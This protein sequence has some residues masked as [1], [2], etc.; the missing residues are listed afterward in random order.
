MLIDIGDSGFEMLDSN[1]VA[2]EPWGHTMPVALTENPRTASGH[3]YADRTGVAYEFPP[4]YRRLI[5]PGTPFVYHRGWE[6]RSGPIYF[7]TGIVGDV[8]PSP[9]GGGLLMADILGFEPFVPPVPFK[10]EE[11]RY[12][13][14]RAERESGYYRQGARRI[15]DE[16]FAAI[17]AAAGREVRSNGATPELPIPTPP[18]PAERD[19]VERYAVERVLELLAEMYGSPAEVKEMPHNHPGYDVRVE[20]MDA[21][22]VRYVEVKGTRSGEPLFRLT[23]GERR[24][25]IEHSNVYTFAM[26]WSIDLEAK[27]HRIEMRDG[28]VDA[29]A[30]R[31]QPTGWIGAFPL[32]NR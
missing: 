16:E 23:E 12:F 9:N 26:V 29:A 3:T 19:A 11:G 10:D 31:L 8:R 21:G 28:T 13:E 4:I 15:T 14:R 18:P 2:A 5:I 30:Y 6:G 22:V 24:F 1:R 17:L 27:T 32:A 25:S 20:A 7:G